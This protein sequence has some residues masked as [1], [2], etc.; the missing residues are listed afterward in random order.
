MLKISV[1][2]SSHLVLLNIE[3]NR[4]QHFQCDVLRCKIWESYVRGIS[5]TQLRCQ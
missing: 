4:K 2:H 5:G 1:F 3:I